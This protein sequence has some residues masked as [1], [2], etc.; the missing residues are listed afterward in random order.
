MRLIAG[1]LASVYHK[2]PA[3][4]IEATVGNVAAAARH[5]PSLA[6]ADSEAGGAASARPEAPPAATVIPAAGTLVDDLLSLDA[7][8][9]QATP[10]TAG[11]AG[12]FKC[13]QNESFN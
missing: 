12:A 5:L 9:T 11:P 10:A 13:F 8:A 6:A 7:P 4:F 3:T 2:P 1:T